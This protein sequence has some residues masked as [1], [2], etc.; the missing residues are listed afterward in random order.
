MHRRETSLNKHEDRGLGRKY[1]RASET[2]REKKE[3]IIAGCR[4]KLRNSNQM[5]EIFVLVA[6]TSQ[7]ANR[8]TLMVSLKMKVEEKAPAVVLLPKRTCGKNK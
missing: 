6:I 8:A 7:I 1:R 5:T 2:E 4:P 3:D